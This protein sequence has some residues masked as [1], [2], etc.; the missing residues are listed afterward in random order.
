MIAFGALGLAI[1]AMAV[2]WGRGDFPVEDRTTVDSS[3]VIENS[4]AVGTNVPSVLNRERPAVEEPGAVNAPEV[5]R[6][7]RLRVRVECRSAPC[8]GYACVVYAGVETQELGVMAARGETDDVGVFSVMLGSGVY[9]VCGEDGQQARVELAAG[10]EHLLVWQSAG[11][12]VW[13][14][15]VDSEGSG[16]PGAVVV[17]CPGDVSRSGV[18]FAVTDEGGGFEGDVYG[19][20][21]FLYAEMDGR[22]PSLMAR[23]EGDPVTLRIGAPSVKISGVVVSAGGDEVAGARLVHGRGFGVRYSANG[24]KLG[25]APPRA[26]ATSGVNGEFSLECSPASTQV[27]CRAPGFATWEG[28]IG[29]GV[30]SKLQARQGGGLEIVDVRIPMSVALSVEGQVVGPGGGPVA[31]ALIQVGQ[32]GATQIRLR[33]D[34]AGKFVISELA[35]GTHEVRA[36]KLLASGVRWVGRE[37]IDG[38]DRDVVI[39][40]R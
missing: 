40:V 25:Y 12:F 3:V 17:R 5:A 38:D 13:G 28:E 39:Y 30:L 7:C 27:V 9:T 35:P 10:Q 32:R 31:D 22:A 21:P 34:A 33:T 4:N 14:T 26:V 29:Q 16:V 24:A 19:E 2:A 1:T 36:F 15:V 18:A 20:R 6:E 23:W 8:T 11:R 37:S